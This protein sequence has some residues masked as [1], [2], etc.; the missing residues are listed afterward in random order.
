MAAEK[1]I[2]ALIQ[3]SVS[4]DLD[5][6]LKRTMEKVKE[7]ASKGAQIVCLQELFRM[8]YFPQWDGKDAA[9]LAETI[10]GPS[11]E[12]F[13]VLARELQ[14]VVIV[15]VFEKDG[16]GFYNSVAVIDADGS[17]LP[18][19]R[20][21]HVPHDPL[22]YEQSYFTPGEEIRVYD[23]RYAKFAALICYD[24]WFPE[25]ARV[26]ALGGAQII[27]YPTA[28]G[29][30]KG[31]ED[32]VEGDWH[33]AWET[34]QRSHA[35]ANS[36]YVAA[37]NR[38]GPE[39][40]LIFW[41]S[42][43]VCDPFGKIL[44]R[45]SSNAEEVL[46]VELDLSHN[47]AVRE[48]WGFFRN[49]RPDVYW[50]LIEMVQEKEKLPRPEGKMEGAGLCLP[51]TPRSLGYHM[52][53][54]WE[55][56]EAIW[57]SWPYDLDSFPEIEAVENAYVAIIKAIHQSEIV[58]LLVK[59]EMLLRAVV[60]RLKNEKVDL[61]RVHFHLINYAD[62]WFRDYGPTFVVRENEAGKEVAA[63][64]W[65]FN[66]WG[67][68]YEELM[69]DT[70]IG[71]LINDDL[72]MERFRPGIVLEGGS[73][74]VNGCGTVLTTEQ[75]LLNRNRNPSLSKEKIEGYLREFLGVSKVI[76]LKEGIAGDDTDGHVDDIARFVDPTTVLCAYEDDP[77]DENYPALKQNYELLCRETDQDGLPLTVI[78]LPMPGRVGG[79]RRLPA[80][81]A[82]F[83]IGND[84]V[85]VPVFG[86]KNDSVALKII[87]EAFPSRR[88]VGINC[89]E[90]VHGLGTVHCV[91]QQQPVG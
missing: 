83:Y 56:H 16:S 35:I 77:E 69:A 4:E 70:K 5:L 9:A 7:A 57:L 66:A 31:E 1:I 3:T 58:N 37:A 17:L 45:A 64:N 32:P 61:R 62:V 36:V 84:V 15:P 46:V 73:I 55:R 75:C 22:F 27:F 20:K 39:E 13:C 76:W 60:D 18:T 50:P 88:A 85:M 11:T 42:S 43:F 14:I 52:P 67:E 82:N 81:Y 53:A 38:V 65:I 6:N 26:A 47:E 25:A 86:H 21:V 78:K 30:I 63:V 51:D 49:R 29:W 10:P 80:S 23:T 8:R 89:R 72:K 44:A 33:D 19:Y 74:D 12:A 2:I 87:G 71:S 24:Q 40:D 48:G 54:E 28:I 41:G 59:D 91:S 90:M 79:E 68:K 34:V